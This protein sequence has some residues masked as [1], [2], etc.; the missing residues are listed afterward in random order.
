MASHAE[1]VPPPPY[2]ETDIFSASGRDAHFADD[3]SR[4]TTSTNGDVIYTP[5]L[6]PRSSHQSNF[7]GEVDLASDS[8]AAAYFESRPAPRLDSQPY[9]VHSISL[10]SD[11]TPDTLPYP[12]NLA[13]RDVRLQ[14]WQ[15]FINYLI[16]HHSA[17]S[18]EQVIDRKLRAE[19]MTTTTTSTPPAGNKGNGNNGDDAHSQASA[20]SHA[21]AHLNRVRS[22]TVD[23]DAAQQAQNVESTVREWNDG[24]FTPRRVTILVDLQPTPAANNNNNNNNNNGHGTPAGLNEVPP[25]PD[26]QQMPGAWD[27]SFDQ[28]GPEGD[29]NAPGA[30]GRPRFG[31]FGPFAGRGGGRGGHGD[32]GRGGFRFAGINVENDRVSIGNNFVADGRTGS[33]RIGGIVADGNGISINGQPM[34]GGAGGRGGGPMGRG[35]FGGGP[36]GWGRRG[37][38]GWGAW[39]AGGAAARG[40]WG[41]GGWWNQGPEEHCRGRRERRGRHDHHHHDRHRSRSSSASSSSS[42]SSSA[43]SESSAGS[44]PDYDDLKDTQLP[45]TKQLL[46]EWLHHPDQPITKDGV[47]QI[48][49]RI[50]AAKHST[51]AAVLADKAALR[52]E[53]KSLL[54]DWKRLKKEQKRA[55]KQLRRDLK[56]RRRQ[57]KREH[58]QAKR[59]MKRAAHDVRREWRHGPFGMP[60]MPPMPHAPH[61]P[62]PP[63]MPA[64]PHMPHMPP[65]PPPPFDA[66]QPRSAPAVPGGF[67]NPLAAFWNNWAGGNNN[68]NPNTSANNNNNNNHN[69]P[70]GAWLDT[71]DRDT[72]PPPSEGVFD[73]RPSLQDHIRYPVSAGKYQAAW[74]VEA[75]VAEKEAELVALHERI[76]EDYHYRDNSGSGEKARGGGSTGPSSKMDAEAVAVEKEIEELARVM[77]RLRT[78]AD[79]EFARELAEEEERGLR[80]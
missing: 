65:M 70:P 75:R 45:V 23:I 42:R 58:R 44:L 72:N 9:L 61:M 48:K 12:S 53:V 68:N 32:A 11:S 13:S 43:H 47:K 1:D 74:V 60:P 51:D 3:A 67:P 57:E 46:E 62:P 5:P 27:Q 73:H 30:A 15:T 22:P 59:E 25:Q 8:A 50:K 26:H 6:T 76:A 66:T 36:G 28:P 33:L 49:E 64:G 24:F 38:G 31:L 55:R 54:N 79:E 63:H 71:K 35:G 69:Q 80:G 56:Q 29:R 21:E 40:G 41:R 37:P 34:F 7:V 17:A 10:T 78:E 18:N 39:G 2:S 77:E 14:D 16:P 4:S 19:A 52:R 20:Q